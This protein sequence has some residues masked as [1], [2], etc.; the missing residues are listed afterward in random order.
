MFSLN[1]QTLAADR[2]VIL[3]EYAA[4]WTPGIA[5]LAFQTWGAGGP[6]SP[7]A[8]QVALL[9]KV[10]E[11]DFWKGQGELYFWN[12][13]WSS[14]NQRLCKV[15]QNCQGDPSVFWILF[16]GMEGTFFI[17]F[18]YLLLSPLRKTW[19]KM[20]IIFEVSFDSIITYIYTLYRGMQNI[21]IICFY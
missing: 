1:A 21:L 8:H 15:F 3:K 20:S 5:V 10:Q 16:Q 18:L 11:N 14:E 4:V 19:I 13:R 2:R 7:H 17:V 12:D 6:V 9:V